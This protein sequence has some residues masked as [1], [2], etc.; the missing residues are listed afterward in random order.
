[1]SL[2]KLLRLSQ[3]AA[4]APDASA[5]VRAAADNLTR[6]ALLLAK[7]AEDDDAED[8]EPDDGEGGG[9]DSG[10]D[11][12]ED[13][14]APKGKGK[15]PFPGAKTPVK[16][17]GGKAGKKPFPWSDDD[18]SKG[19]KDDKVKAAAELVQ[20]AMVALSQLEGGEILRLSSPQFTGPGMV[21]ALAKGGSDAVAMDHGPMSGEHEHPHRV[22]N[23]HSHAH[24]HNGDSRHTCGE[25]SYG[26][27]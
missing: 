16:G 9:S 8:Q 13:D 7:K 18:K 24:T 11:D 20:S 27:Y 14:D 10:D 23:V 25:R 15:K 4:P 21:L 1:M 19:G 22:M 17:K 6:V 2:D 3:P 26:D 5:L 12:E